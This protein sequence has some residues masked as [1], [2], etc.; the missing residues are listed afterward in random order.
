MFPYIFFLTGSLYIA[1]SV[2]VLP[3]WTRMTSN[4]QS[5]SASAS[6]VLE[7]KTCA[8]PTCQFIKILFFFALFVQT[9]SFPV[10]WSWTWCGPA[11]FCSLNSDNRCVSPHPA[12]NCSDEKDAFLCS[13]LYI[14]S[15]LFD[16]QQLYC[17]I[18][19]LS[20]DWCTIM[21][22]YWYCSSNLHYFF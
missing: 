20:C 8:W 2:L 18:L 15:F 6:W 3:V 22:L 9:G 14:I 21:N 13:S 11:A 16:F 19:Q 10:A 17:Y 4:S 5:P 7:L 1:L 12:Y